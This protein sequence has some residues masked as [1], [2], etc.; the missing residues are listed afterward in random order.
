M[1]NTIDVNKSL[2]KISL[3]EWSLHNSIESGKINHLDFPTIAKKQFGIDAVEYVNTLFRDMSTD[4]E[5]LMKLKMNADNEGVKNLLIMCDEEGSL[6]D[7]DP[8]K[9]RRAVE[10]HFRWVD[11]AKF[12]GCHSIRINAHPI[13]F[14]PRTLGISE[15]DMKK[16][17]AD[18]IRQLTEFAENVGINV[19]IENHGGL[20]SKSSW[21]TSVVRE[22]N[23]PRFGTLPDFGNPNINENEIADSYELVSALMPYAKGVSAKSE[24]FED[25]DKYIVG[26]DAF[27]FNGER[28]KVDYKKMIQIVLDANYSGYIGVEFQSSDDKYEIEGITKTTN[29]LRR[30]R[31]ELT[32]K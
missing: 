10:N 27:Y 30:I 9:R 24:T 3:A 23:H 1:M 25:E 18:G 28:V 14:D 12:L 21:L 13:D 15:E 26:V 7:I 8:Q 17:A 32:Q 19:L 11:A 5:Y 29:I 20:S 22:V 31:N 2:F 6:S 16:L 4:R